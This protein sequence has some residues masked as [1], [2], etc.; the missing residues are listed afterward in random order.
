MP[1]CGRY[2]VTSQTEACRG[3]HD[4]GVRGAAHRSATPRRPRCRSSEPRCARAFVV[5]RRPHGQ[6]GRGGCGWSLLLLLLG[7][8]AVRPALRRC[9]CCCCCCCRCCFGTRCF[10]RRR[11]F[12]AFGRARAPLPLRCRSRACAAAARGVVGALSALLPRQAHRSAPLRVQAARSSC[13]ER[14]AAASPLPV[15]RARARVRR[16]DARMGGTA[17]GWLL[18]RC[19]C[20]ALALCALRCCCCCCC[21]SFASR[22]F[23][24]RRRR[25]RAFGRARCHCAAA[26]VPVLLLVGSVG[27]LVLSA[28]LRRT[29]LH[30]LHA[31]SSPSRA[32]SVCLSVDPARFGE[33]P[34]LLYLLLFYR[35]ALGKIARCDIFSSHGDVCGSRGTFLCQSDIRTRQRSDAR[36]T[37]KCRGHGGTAQH[38][39]PRR[40]LLL[41]EYVRRQHASGSYGCWRDRSSKRGALPK[42]VVDMQ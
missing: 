22:C 29:V 3:H 13:E 24:R 8:C 42:T 30:V 16:S 17:R 5:R 23:R 34:L 10:R 2:E 7:A 27:A 28:H 20:S 6:C 19:C 41:I 25:F 38:S 9:C 11:R 12:R 4:R 18:L 1:S 32:S 35:G 39:G 14:N 36:R 21:C 15:I 26:R 31:R 33:H 37:T 40:A